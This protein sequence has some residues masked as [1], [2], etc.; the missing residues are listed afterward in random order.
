M[1]R[2]FTEEEM[3]PDPPRDPPRFIVEEPPAEGE[4][5]EP[6]PKQLSWFEQNKITRVPLVALGEDMHKVPGQAFVCFSVIRPEDYGVLHHKDGKTQGSTLIKFRGAFATREEADVHI[7]KL[8]TADPHFD[9]HLIPCG[10]WSVLDDDASLE[11]IEYAEDQ[12]SQIMRS[13][14]KRENDSKLSLAERIEQDRAGEERGEEATRFFEEAN[15]FAGEEE[16]RVQIVQEEPD[17]ELERR[18]PI[19]LAELARQT[20]IQPRP[21]TIVATQTLSEERKETIHSSILET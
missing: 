14:F 16:E 17:S 11:N 20:Q 9:I 8:M 12:I 5:D 21:R 10:H 2:R 7:R 6:P 19:T 3:T 18:A 4:S 15:R 1:P 13:Y